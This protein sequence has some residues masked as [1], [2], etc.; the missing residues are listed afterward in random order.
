[1]TTHGTTKET[2]LNQNSKQAYDELSS[3]F[4]DATEHYASKQ[5]T[6]FFASCIEQ[7]PGKVLEAMSGSGRLQIPLMQRGYSIDGVDH[8]EA[9]LARCRQRCAE[10]GLQPVIF[11][12]SLE[13]LDL[14][15]KY[16][17]VII[18]VGSLQLITDQDMVLR[19]L[20]NLKAHMLP[21]GNLVLDTFKPD[22]TL[23]NFAT[24]TVLLGEQKAIRLTK[25]HVFNVEQK[26]V[27][28]FCLYELLVNGI[29]VQQENELI[30][31]VW[32]SDQ[33]WQQLLL[34]AGFQTVNISDE[35]LRKSEPSRII[36]AKSMIEA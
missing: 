15:Y 8:S 5:E 11:K 19:V 24:S 23:D 33:E 14:P 12:Q 17:T 10:L 4:Y 25:R 6:D 3:L 35:I 1:M 29:I 9:M 16:N 32:R 28:S 34:K 31:I 2:L 20:R 18:A 30:E 22:I 27:D 13:N 21:G 36:H 7:H 26:R